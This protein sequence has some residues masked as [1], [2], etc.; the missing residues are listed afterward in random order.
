[1]SGRTLLR[2]LWDAHVVASPAVGPALLYIDLHLLHESTSPGAFEA[3]RRRGVP[4][5]RPD[6][7]VATM[8]HLTPTGLGDWLSA[9]AQAQLEGLRR[10]CREHGIRLLDLGNADRGIVHVIG[11]ELGLTR[12][13]MTVACA[14]SHA[15]TQG[16]LGALAFSI[17]AAEVETVLAT[18]C[19]PVE[20]PRTFEVFVEGKLRPGVGAKD[21]MLA[22]LERIGVDGACG[23]ALELTGPTIDR[24][25]IEQRMTLCNMAAETGARTALIAPDDATFDYVARAEGGPQGEEL[26]AAIAAWGELRSDHDARH[27]RR[28]AIDVDDLEPMITWGTTPGMGMPITG[29]VPDPGAYVDPG[30]REALVDALRYME[31]KPGEPLLGR[32]V[33]AVFIG[34]C[35]NG[36]LTDLIEAARVLRG[37]TVAHGVRALVVPGSQRVK[38]D[39]EA[40]GLD[41]I[42]ERAGAQWREPGCSMCAGLESDR[43]EPGTRAVSTGNR[44][45]P[46]RQG[47]R[48]RTYLA[49]PLTAAAAAV[50][51]EITD[52]R[53][54]LATPEED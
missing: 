25:D 50:T 16:A 8:D 42:F 23:H 41:R 12:P 5:R 30:H 26:D 22:L 9:R 32:P 17:G 15:S 39:A 20:R 14:D 54:L 44:N 37:R 3:L 33:E 49:S 45:Y 18:Q 10:G 7:T 46:G 38:R 52:V 31:L 2:K 43:L 40:L 11:P 51:G 1:M 29:R 27:D 19:L 28:I 35:A 13:G 21:V 6:L 48:V 53:K 36:R 24:L 47:E 4:V 34:S